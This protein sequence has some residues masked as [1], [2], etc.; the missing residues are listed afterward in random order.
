VVGVAA[1]GVIS[2]VAIPHVLDWT[3]PPV[4]EKTV[5]AAAPAPTPD[6]PASTPVPVRTERRVDMPRRGDL[7]A[8]H[9]ASERYL[10]VGLDEQVHMGPLDAEVHDA[11]LRPTGHGA[12][13]STD[14]SV[15]LGPPQVAHLWC[16]A[17]HH[18]QRILGVDLGPRLVPR[19]RPRSIWQLYLNNSGR[20]SAIKP[21]RSRQTVRAWR[22]E[23]LTMRGG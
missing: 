9:A 23:N 11:K 15:D 3:R 6:P 13:R 1:L 5:T 12:R 2:A 19:A 20:G 17:Q 7:E 4:L 14:R 16:C 21:S 18:V 10:V 8:L 22:G